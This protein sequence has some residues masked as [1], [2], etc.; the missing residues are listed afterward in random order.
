M[1][2]NRRCLRFRPRANN[3][4]SRPYSHVTI[5]ALYKQVLKGKK[6]LAQVLSEVWLLGLLLNRA[7]TRIE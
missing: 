7:Y 2:Y 5:G 4:T 1:G 6:C 3:Y